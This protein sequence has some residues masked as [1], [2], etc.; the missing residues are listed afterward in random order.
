VLDLLGK[1]C[2]KCGKCCYLP[3]GKG[4][5]SLRACPFLIKKDKA[6]HCQIYNKRLG[7]KIGS[8]NGNDVFCT[9]YNSLDTEIIDCPLND[10]SKPKRDV[11]IEPKNYKKAKGIIYIKPQN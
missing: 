11:I 4:D 6:Y 10:G 1:K 9:M 3:T 2:N 7:V 5:G 8:Y